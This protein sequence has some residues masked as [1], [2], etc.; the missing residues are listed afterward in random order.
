MTSDESR[1]TSR[2]RIS[3]PVARHSSLSASSAIVLSLLFHP[4]LLIPLTI[5]A[6]TRDLRLTALVAATT[7][8]PLL[9][10]TLAKVRRG[11]W[12]D[13]DVSD[14]AQ[15]GGFYAIAVLLTLGGAALAFAT[16]APAPT[17]KWNLIGT[18]MLLVA[19]V[20]S[21][22]VLKVSLHLMFVGWAGVVLGMEYRSVLAA[23]PVVM[24]ALG[25]SRLRLQRHTFAEVCAGAAIGLA[26]G[27]ISLLIR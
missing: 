1:V 17:V 13:F 7:V 16:L 18:A 11:S 10:I 23:A 2:Q 3:S 19:F 26:G 20:L 6:L 27:A 24:L 4:F 8:L 15:R 21:R 14:R 12:A 5:V 22:F 9:A 25:W